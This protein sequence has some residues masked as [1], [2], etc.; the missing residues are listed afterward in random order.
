MCVRV[1]RRHFLFLRTLFAAGGHRGRGGEESVKRDRDASK[2]EHA[3]TL[4]AHV[5]PHCRQVAEVASPQE[6]AHAL[7]PK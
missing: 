7:A 2:V 6:L 5:G 1:D 4:R 3:E